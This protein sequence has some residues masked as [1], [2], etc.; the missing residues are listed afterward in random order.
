[1]KNREK[2]LIHLIKKAQI[3]FSE[4][5]YVVA[6][7]GF[8]SKKFI[9]YCSMRDDLNLVI[10]YIQ[11]LREIPDNKIFKSA[12]TYSLIALYGKCFTDASK[13]S[14][15]KLEPNPLFDENEAVNNPRGK[16][17]RHLEE[18]IFLIDENL[19]FSNFPLKY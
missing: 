14:Y 19:R 10:D 18:H 9:A 3:E 16:P 7:P 11:T 6:I 4:K 15:P 8:M 17:T 2:A 12:L 13:N 1:M 5:N